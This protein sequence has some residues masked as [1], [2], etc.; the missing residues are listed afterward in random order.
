MLRNSL[1]KS[2]NLLGILQHDPETWF[3]WR[4]EGAAAGLSDA[5]IEARIAARLG[6]RKGRNFAEA[7]R[8]RKE[9]ADAGITLEDGAAGTTWRRS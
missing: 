4:P 9:L 5:D 3:K 7:D 8:I 6:A 1:R 2:G